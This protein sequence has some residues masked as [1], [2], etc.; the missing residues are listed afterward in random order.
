[1]N[2]DD[3]PLFTRLEVLIDEP[4]HQGLYNMA[5]DEVLL[6][7]SLRLPLLR[8]YRWASPT[9][10]FGYFEPWN[11]VAAQYPSRQM[12]RRWTG[13]GVVDHAQDWSYSLLLP[14]SERVTN[15]PA[16]TSYRWIHA[17][18]RDAMTRAGF[19][20]V[21]LH[22]ELDVSPHNASHACFVNAVQYDLLAAGR[23]VSG[24][25]QRRTRQGLLHQ[26][27]V[28]NL[29]E[30]RLGLQG[31]AVWLPKILARETCG[32]SVLP[33]EDAAAHR[34]VTAKYATPAWL[35]RV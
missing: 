15:L 35:H 17:K 19:S 34:L 7:S 10:S 16:G 8:L 22:G 13:G 30:N 31:L 3:P 20:N 1:M 26:G 24:A 23:K 14:R 5:L 18:L 25:A 33:D 4:P 9:V 21:V 11:P 32:R 12:V 28:Q 2:V 6:C 27:S 29:P